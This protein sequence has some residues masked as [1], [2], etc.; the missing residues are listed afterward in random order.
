MIH[1]SPRAVDYFKLYQDWK[2]KTGQ[3]HFRLGSIT[4][5]SVRYGSWKENIA[6]RGTSKQPFFLILFSEESYIWVLPEDSS[7]TQS[8]SA[9]KLRRLFE[10]T[11]VHHDKCN[12][13]GLPGNYWTL[14][15]WS[16][17]LN[18]M[19]HLSSHWAFRRR[20]QSSIY[21][22]VHAYIVEKSIDTR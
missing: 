11:R 5:L 15:I 17:L 16:E 19:R 6:W 2:D 9:F 10:I 20:D 7:E 13:Q 21:F 4:P 22:E 18:V 1:H 3:F 12:N 14:I 8:Q